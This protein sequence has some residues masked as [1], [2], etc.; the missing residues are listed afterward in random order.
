[1]EMAFLRTEHGIMQ[2]VPKTPSIFSDFLL[3]EISSW[4]MDAVYYG[5]II[6]DKILVVRSLH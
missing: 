2:G 4:W 1:L 6:L 5:V 3:D